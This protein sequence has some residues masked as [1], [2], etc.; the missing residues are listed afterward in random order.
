MSQYTGYAI[1]ILTAII[2]SVWVAYTRRSLSNLKR[3]SPELSD[4][5]DTLRGSS[6]QVGSVSR[7][8]IVSAN[9]QLDTLNSTVAACHQI[10]AMG[11]RTSGASS[12][13][14]IEASHLRN[15]A[16][17]GQSVM[18]AMVS[19]SQEI[20]DGSETFRSAIQE[21]IDQLTASLSVIREIADKTKVI[22]EI[23]FQT[24]LLSFNASVEAARAGEHGKG[25]AVVAEEVG[26][27]AHMSGNAAREIS[28]IVDRSVQTVN[29]AIE[30]AKSRVE[31]MTEDTHIMSE[32]GFAYSQKGAEIFDSM[33][34]KIT[35]VSR[36]IEQI[37]VATSEQAV[38]VN[39]LDQS[40]IQLQEVASRNRL[41]AS[42]TSEHANEFGQQ[43]V[44]LLQI[45]NS[46][47][48][49]T[50]ANNQTRDIQT[51]QW[52]DRL[53]LKI[54][55]MDNEHKILVDKINFLIKTLNAHHRN[56]DQSSLLKAFQDL[57]AYVVKHFADE[58]AFMQQIDYPQFPSHKK[59]HEK[60][61][62][63]VSEYGRA[64]EKGHLDDRKLV[65][66]LRNW[67]ISHIMGVDMQYARHSQE[68][69]SGSSGRRAA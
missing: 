59:I 28:E 10:A 33:T 42:Q 29:S 32:T 63:Q 49:S 45:S 7:E 60:L 30:T 52:S 4:V 57:G 35:E 68:R 61:L 5:C 3:L 37:S 19:S 40:I 64:I 31:K 22:N 8:I 38:G 1:A 62:Q 69:R 56:P 58:E 50:G 13:L 44:E 39:E 43:T 41:V 65:A 51:F 17:D 67:L 34:N 25:F 14:N 6:E 24:K 18:K 20:K 2:C 27:L 12:Q 53:T 66:F 46:I 15:M 48:K 47:L 16:A 54:D 55:S 9:E 21:S 36:M 23:V 26:S 11:E